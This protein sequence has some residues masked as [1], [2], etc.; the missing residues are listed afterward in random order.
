MVQARR[1][2][3]A[4][5][6]RRSKAGRLG[7]PRSVRPEDLN[8]PNG[9]GVTV[10][11]AAAPRAGSPSG[12]HRRH[13]AGPR[14]PAIKKAWPETQATSSHRGDRDDNQPAAPPRGLPGPTG[15]APIGPRPK[16]SAPRAGIRLGV[17]P[18]PHRRAAVP[19][20]GSWPGRASHGARARPGSRPRSAV[21]TVFLHFRSSGRGRGGW[22]PCGCGSLR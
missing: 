15:P 4:G 3:C 21:N 7:E 19:H 2:S 17:L 12:L 5:S 16:E 9:P 20:V 22:V 18:P 6:P 1:P 10:R 14:R 8:F 11:P 13:T